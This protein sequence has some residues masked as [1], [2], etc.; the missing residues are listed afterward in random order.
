M[1]SSGTAVSKNCHDVRRLNSINLFLSLSLSS[2]LSIL[3]GT[4]ILPCHRLSPYARKYAVHACMLS[5]VWLF[6]TPWATAC[7]ASLSMGFPRQE[8]WSG[9]P[10]PSPG[11][12]PDPGMEPV[13]PA[14]AG[15]FF[16]TELPGKPSGKTDTG[17]SGLHP[18]S[19]WSKWKTYF[20][21]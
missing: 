8:Y 12:F 1:W 10:G 15:G 6:T 7:Q 11:D 2:G 16:T 18:Y 21:S 9:L 17:N 5:R 4:F 20:L 3:H 19:I 14:L 13:S